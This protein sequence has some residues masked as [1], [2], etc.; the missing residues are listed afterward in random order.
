[1]TN[2][3]KVTLLNATLATLLL[4]AAA[5][6]SS[7]PAQTN[8]NAAQAPATATTSPTPNQGVNQRKA[9]QQNRIAN[10]I[11][12]G[13]LTKGE[14]G[15]LEGRE[16]QLNQE[17]SNM[18]KL[19]NGHLTAADR[20]TLQQQQ[21]KLSNQIHQDAHNSNVQTTHPATEVGQRE[22][23]QQKSIASGIKNDNLSAGQAS[24][25]ENKE[26]DINQEVKSDRAANGGKL[27]QAEKSQVTKQQ[28]GVA[29][30]VH[31]EKQA[32]NNKRKTA[33]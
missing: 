22:Q 21:N 12:N 16:S 6:T 3:I 23:D 24:K 5:Q 7:A 13:S 20:A 27:T 25:L 2:F 1:M 26:A 18:K 33:K 10:G 8:A 30:Q 11:D 4:P 29:Y 32:H 9:N 15:N 31:H 17:E 19:D 14:A 28:N